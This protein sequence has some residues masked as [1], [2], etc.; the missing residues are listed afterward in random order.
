MDKITPIVLFV[1]G[2]I[3]MVFPVFG[4]YGKGMTLLIASSGFNIFALGILY[5]NVE[6]RFDQLEDKR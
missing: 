5:Q 6:F 3:I 4:D 1:Y 2:I